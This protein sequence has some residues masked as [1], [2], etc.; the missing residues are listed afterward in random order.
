VI[1]DFTFPAR[2][3]LGISEPLR[4]LAKNHDNSD[5]F[6]EAKSGRLTSLCMKGVTIDTVFT[7][8][9]E[10]NAL[11]PSNPHVS[12]QIEAHEIDSAQACDFPVVAG[13]LA[14][15]FPDYDFS[16][17]APR[18]FRLIK[19]PEAAR[20]GIAWPLSSALGIWGQ[21]VGSFWQMLAVDPA[22]CIY[23]YE[24]DCADPFS[25]SGVVSNL[26]YCF[27]EQERDEGRDVPFAR[28]SK[29]FRIGRRRF[30]GQSG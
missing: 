28:G 18:H 4:R 16:C 24:P 10:L 19:S 2:R 26:W 23:A 1:F 9:Q 7:A 8:N 11:C 6:S 17:V 15:S 29:R 12:G 21:R 22:G 25:Q 5:L 27:C 20:D 3:A 13:A 30:G 14:L